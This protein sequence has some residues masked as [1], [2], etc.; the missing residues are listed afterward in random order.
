MN[1]DNRELKIT[2]RHLPHWTMEGVLYFITFR[3]ISNKLS[4]DEQ[5]LVLD[6]IIKGNNKYYN[7][8]ATIVMPDHVHLII[9]PENEYNLSKIL[10]GIKGATARGINLMRKS[11]GSIWQGESFDRIIRS[12]D[13]LIEKLNYML[14]NPIKNG[15]TENPW[16]YHGWYIY[17]NMYIN[18]DN[19]E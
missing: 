17:N 15:L 7:L 14:N 18:K 11:K 19:E 16:E 3:T 12:Q 5:R 2:K 8:I 9:K 6:N 1:M 13:E 10:R 4:I